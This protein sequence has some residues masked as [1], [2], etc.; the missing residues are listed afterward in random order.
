MQ[1]RRPQAVERRRALFVFTWANGTKRH[2][3]SID[4]LIPNERRAP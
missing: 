3:F 1:A 2:P 4:F